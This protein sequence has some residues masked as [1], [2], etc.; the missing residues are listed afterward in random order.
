MK[1]LVD[2]QLPPA[3]A[4]LIR[5]KFKA[6]AAHVA[7][8]GLRDASDAELWGHASAS[9]SVLISKD[10]DFANMAL[11][12]LT[13]ELVW[14][15]IGNCRRAFLLDLFRRIWPRIAEPAGKR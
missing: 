12:T 6:D 1:F 2:N 5:T 13:A 11:Q 3:L 7:D 4:R 10:E 14:V 9:G 15:R 8:L